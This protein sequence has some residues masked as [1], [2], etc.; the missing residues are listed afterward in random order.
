MTDTVVFLTRHLVTDTQRRDFPGWRIMQVK[1]RAE[2]VH[3]LWLEVVLATG[4]APQVIVATLPWAWQR[5]FVKHVAKMSPNTTVVRALTDSE[6]A[7]PTGRYLR[8]C[9]QYGRG[10]YFDEYEPPRVQYL[11]GRKN[12]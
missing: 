6:N 7:V 4:T 5:Y 3:R 12:E 10:V 8:Y 11:N 2:S 9:Y 1:Y